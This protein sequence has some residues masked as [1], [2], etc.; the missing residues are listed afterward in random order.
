M[1]DWIARV[2]LG[3]LSAVVVED[4]FVRRW[5]ALIEGE[6]SAVFVPAFEV[7]KVEGGQALVEQDVV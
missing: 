6:G 4:C 3:Q 2:K 5:A 7:V 1:L